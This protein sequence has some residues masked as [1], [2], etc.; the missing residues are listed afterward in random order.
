MVVNEPKA[1]K[2]AQWDSAFCPDQPTGQY[3]LADLPQNAKP[4]LRVSGGQITDSAAAGQWQVLW[5]QAGPWSIEV[6][7]E[8]APGC[9]P[10]TRTTQVEERCIEVMNLATPNGDGV[11]DAFHIRN[12]DRYQDNELTIL[13]RWGKKVVSQARFNNDIQMRNWQAGTYF[14]LLKISYGGSQRTYQ[15]W[16]EL[17]K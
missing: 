7:A 11:N 15:G 2:L 1:I 5:S 12:I 16:I 17:V 9:P 3:K 10:A 14:Y 4:T 6:Q 8:T 13:N